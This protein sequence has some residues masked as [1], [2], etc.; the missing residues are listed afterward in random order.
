MDIIKRLINKIYRIGGTVIILVATILVLLRSVTPFISIEPYLPANFPHEKAKLI[1]EGWQPGIR[2]YNVSL[3]EPFQAKFRRV[4][5]ILNWPASLLSREWRLKKISIHGVQTEILLDGHAPLLD[6]EWWHDIQKALRHHWRRC[7]IFIVE[8]VDAGIIQQARLIFSFGDTLNIRGAG[9]IARN[10]AI[11]IN[12]GVALKDWMSQKDEVDGLLYLNVFGLPL[13]EA[14]SYFPSIG[15]PHIESGKTSLE[16]WTYLKDKAPTRG[17]ILLEGFD[18]QIRD[19]LINNRLDY[20]KGSLGFTRRADQLELWGK[21]FHFAKT[22]IDRK[23]IKKTLPTEFNLKISD[24]NIEYRASALGLSDWRPFLSSLI[25]LPKPLK[26]LLS[27]YETEGTVNFLHFSVDSKYRPEFVRGKVE[28]LKLLS[29][30]LPGFKGLTGAFVYKNKIGRAEIQGEKLTLLHPKFFSKPLKVANPRGSIWWQ[31]DASEVG[32]TVWIEQCAG[33]LQQTPFFASLK[34]RN[35]PTNSEIDLYAKMDAIQ[36]QD[37]HSLLPKPVMNPLL[38]EWLDAA[39]KQGTLESTEARVKGPLKHFPFAHQE[40]TFKI[41]MSFKD[42]T[43]NYVHE[44]PELSHLTGHIEFD[45]QM[46]SIEANEG[47]IAE[48]PLTVKAWIRDLT[49]PVNKLTIQAEVDS[50]LEKGLEVVQH[51]PLAKTL[52]RSLSPFYLSGPMLLSLKLNIPLAQE[53]DL[54][55]DV[56]GVVHVHDAQFSVKDWALDINE[57]SGDFV[58]T[59]NDLTAS[60]VTGNLLGAPTQFSVKS[61]VVDPYS[62][63][64]VKAS[65]YL[66]PEYIA[67]WARREVQSWIEGEAPYSADLIFSSKD[68]YEEGHLKIQSDLKGL[69]I[70]LPEPFDKP[71]DIRQDAELKLFF[72]PNGRLRFQGQYGENITF[73]FSF[74]EEKDE[75]LPLGGQLYFG[76]TD[77]ARYREDGV[78]QINGEIPKLDL[79]AWSNTSSIHHGLDSVIDLNIGAMKVRQFNFEKVMLQGRYNH[80]KNQWLYR[81]NGPMTEG[82]VMVPDEPSKAI[83]LDFERLILISENSLTSTKEKEAKDRDVSMQIKSLL[84]NGKQILDFNLVAQADDEG[85]HLQELKGQSYQTSFKGSGYW[86]PSHMTLNGTA[87]SRN[88]N[89]FLDQWGYG[90]SVKEAAGR[91]AFNVDWE[92]NEIGPKWD[93]LDGTLDVTLSKGYI[94]GVD[95]GLGRILSLISL[96]SIQRRLRLD[97]TDLSKNGL[98]FDKLSGKFK[99]E[100]GLVT[101]QDLFLDGSA[102]RVEFSGALQLPSK[103][104]QAK[105]GVLP[106]VTAGLPLAAA[107]AAGNPA[108]GAAVWIVDKLIGKEL[109]QITRYEY[110]VSGTLTNPEI[111]EHKRT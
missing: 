96:D 107:I 74:R 78:L 79:F 67:E 80:P 5:V 29:R 89:R 69:A 9:K 18:I 101:T 81:F 100:S 94:H 108:V 72:Q 3:T 95:P 1:W 38:V 28:N 52:G 39:L 49:A 30:D 104:V 59:D 75:W 15:L 109:K 73:A 46:I 70:L 2:F 25:F 68:H 99:M 47:R 63:I 84:Y 88:F 57:L 45:R 27:E 56:K 37:M 98:S 93:T 32:R 44:W 54:E 10:D 41:L 20:L 14:V 106:N 8:D 77:Y 23:L 43:L 35:H 42:T 71:K 62:Q 92:K 65:G 87:T 90:S 17:V 6:L 16:A 4:S 48:S 31:E 50:T 58:F 85:Y 11:D 36:I 7:P 91:I 51:S 19:G 66:H 13:T 40:G 55:T 86:D 26:L 102:A 33:D 12:F 83:N 111:S 105:V 21:Q 24:D 61:D 103:A 60:G 34:Y 76:L 53:H 82:I 22:D 97:F 110:D 64:Q